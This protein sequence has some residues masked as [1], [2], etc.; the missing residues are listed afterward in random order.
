MINLER[1]KTLQAIVL[2]LLLIFLGC[3]SHRR[4]LSSIPIDTLSL[5]KEPFTIPV[6]NPRVLSSFG[7]RK[8]TFHTGVDLIEKGNKKG[9]VLAARSGVVIKSR[10][11]K[12]YG[13]MIT[14]HHS[15]GFTSRYAH[16]KKYLVQKGDRVKEGQPIGLIGN[17]GRSSGPHLHFE[18]LTSDWKF[19]D[20]QRIIEFP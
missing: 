19:I 6:K 9:Y 13:K 10:H 18:I 7:K 15:D 3:M 20:P 1:G 14:L 17:S 4:S 11:K 5:P 8:R 12:G 2:G 16:L